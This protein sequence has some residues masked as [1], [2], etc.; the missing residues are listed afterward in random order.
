[1]KNIFKWHIRRVGS[2]F[3]V[4]KRGLLFWYYLD[5]RDFQIWSNATAAWRK[6]TLLATIE[7]ARE[8]I[9]NKKSEYVE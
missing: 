6:Y 2:C 3:V 1:M 5:P 9:H 8:L 4:A 7:Q